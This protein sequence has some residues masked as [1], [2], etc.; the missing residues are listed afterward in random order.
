MF[1]FEIDNT[2]QEDLRIYRIAE[3]ERERER[4]RIRTFDFLLLL[5][6]LPKANRKDNNFTERET[7]T[8]KKKRENYVRLIDFVLYIGLT[9]FLIFFFRECF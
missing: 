2:K 8:T 4:R 1:R 3:I 5:V 7:T 9:I 6:Q